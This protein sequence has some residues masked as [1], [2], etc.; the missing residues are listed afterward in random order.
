[1][2]IVYTHTCDLNEVKFTLV[3]LAGIKSH[4]RIVH[5][6]D[7]DLLEIYYQAAVHYLEQ[8]TN[9]PIHKCLVEV[10]IEV[11]AGEH[12]EE[13]TLDYAPSSDEP[14]ITVNMFP[15]TRFLR[16]DQYSATRVGRWRDL[17]FKFTPPIEQNFKVLYAAG[18]VESAVNY[19]SLITAA[20]LLI[21]A[22]YEL[23][24]S[25]V[26]MNANMNPM[27]DALIAPYR[28]F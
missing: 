15:F 18:F 3:S 7:D 16:D 6:Q 20:L 26:T 13:L 11:A 25:I 2:D 12:V 17:T 21:G 23:R 22:Q 28:R 24:E 19:S 5:D 1:M 9:R 10:A 27:L 4:C 14:G 8:R